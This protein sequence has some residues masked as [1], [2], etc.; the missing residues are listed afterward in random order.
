M[1]NTRLNNLVDGTIAQGVQ[2]FSNPWRKFS[3]LVITFLL[4]N[5]LGTAL[6]T[7]AGQTQRWD[8]LA[9]AALV[10]FT[11]LVSLITY[12]SRRTTDRHL[13]TEILNTLK[14]GLVYGLFVEAFKL[15]S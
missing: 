5:F 3:L 6:P 12:R 8:I 7:T 10:V 2:F 11:E 1:Q 15:G 13:L 9:A 4:G 14:I